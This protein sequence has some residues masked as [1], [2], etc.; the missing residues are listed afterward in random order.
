MGS[1]SWQ[2]LCHPRSRQV[3]CPLRPD[4]PDHGQPADAAARAHAG[5]SAGGHR[6]RC[7][8]AGQR[9]V[10]SVLKLFSNL[11]RALLILGGFA[12]LI[13]IGYFVTIVISVLYVNSANYCRDCDTGLGLLG[14]G[15]GLDLVVTPF[16]FFLL[17][18]ALGTKV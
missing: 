2:Q 11:V 15:Y 10:E 6:R 5:R 7:A 9:G 8:R 18:T 4:A 3:H 13:C 12:L 17:R 16:A 14:I 1:H